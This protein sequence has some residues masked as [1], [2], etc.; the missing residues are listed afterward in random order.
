LSL[1]QGRFGL[2]TIRESLT[3]LGEPQ[4]QIPPAFHVAGTNGKGSTCAFLRTIL[5][6]EGL[7][8]H[9]ATKPHLVRYN[10]RIRVAGKLISDSM[11]AQLLAEVL[12]ISEDLSP[13][14]FEVTTAAMF[15]AFAR[16]PADAC[17]IETGLGGRFDATNVLPHPAAVGIASLGIDHEAFLLRPEPGTPDDPLARIA[18]EK[19]GII[20]PG[21]PTCT[22]A[23]PEGAELEIERA[24]LAAGAPLHI[25]GKDW[26]A[27]GVDVLEYRDRHGA[28]TLP[29]PMLAGAHQVDNAALAIALL[30]HQDRVNVS[31]EAMASGI[32]EARW[33]ARLQLLGDGPLT[34]V[35]GKR[36]VWLDGGHNA[37]AGLAIARHFTG[38]PMHLIIGMMANKDPAAIVAA[39]D[40]TPLTIQT[41]E[42]AGQASHPALAFGALAK[43][44]ASVAAALKALPDDGVSALIAGSLYLAGDVLAQNHE[45][46]D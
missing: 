16:E 6:A 2:E 35:A 4:E 34:A 1:P 12:D 29:L 26:D 9:T 3:R 7:V 38:Q 36:A 27:T 28:L 41:V 15:L 20:R 32:L 31:L 14:F 45:V 5:E 46:P 18:F 25:K 23:Y 17:V 37:D 30:R 22:M 13:S 43:I 21:A 11:L 44:A 42:V 8:V 33:P 40:P 39:L 24:A 19:A 10:E